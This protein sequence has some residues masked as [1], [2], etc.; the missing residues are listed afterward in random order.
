MRAR[1]RTLA[2]SLLVTGV[3]AACAPTMP[4]DPSEARAGG[5]AT[6]DD[7][8][9]GA[10]EHPIDG[11]DD[12]TT[13]AFVVGDSFTTHDWV[14]APASAAAR[15]GLGPLYQATRCSACH[16][17]SGRGAP[18]AEGQSAISTLV[19]LGTADGQP[20]PVYGNQLQE[21]ALLGIAPEGSARTHWVEVSGAYEDGTPFV[22]RGPELTIDGLGYGPLG[23]STRT[24]VRTAP[25]LVG[26]GLLDAVP[27]DAILALEDEV[28]ADRDGISGRASRI[29]DGSGIE[30]VGRFGWKAAQPDLEAQVAAALA[31]DMGITSSLVSEAPCTAAQGACLEAPSGG[32]P[33]AS[34]EIVAAIT[35]YARARAVPAAREIA[36]P[37]VVRGRDLFASAGCDAC[38]VPSLTTGPSELAALDHQRIWPYTDLLL[39]DMGPLLADGRAEGGAD[40]SEWRTPPLWSLGLADVV[41]EGAGYL[42]DGRARDVAEAILWHG[43][44]GQSS[45]AAFV[46]MSSA[47]RD[48]LVRFVRSL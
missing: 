4:R 9:R 36:E 42:H 29:R 37:I 34:D 27:D 45:R 48:A 2:R 28:D 33:E 13:A 35:T 10:L 14:S 30:R 17:R 39:H 12:A 44:E 20:D 16:A 46:S 40:G 38:H 15:D 3:V 26:M 31:G 23:E 19:R 25:A 22:V 6:V 21:R 8:S 32:A 41:S 18:P 7:D 47:E 5:A 11:L 43:G 24:S 1:A